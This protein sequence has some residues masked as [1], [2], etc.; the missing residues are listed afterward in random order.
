MIQKVNMTDDL[1]TKI[2]TNRAEKEFNKKYR[3][4]K[5]NCGEYM[6]DHYQNRGWCS[7]NGC[8]WYWPNDKY[9]LRKKSQKHEKRT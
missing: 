9:L 5:C 6:K 8:T 1:K 7:K 4:I 3:R 2:Q